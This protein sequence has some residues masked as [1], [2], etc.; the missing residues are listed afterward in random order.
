MMTARTGLVGVAL[1]GFEGSAIAGADIYGTGN[2]SDGNVTIAADGPVNTYAAVTAAAAAGTSAVTL[3]SAAGFAVGDLVLVHRSQ[4]LSP[5]A[6]SGDQSDITLAG[7]TG[8]W[9]FA[10]VVGI[11]GSTLTLDAPLLSAV[12]ATGAQVV[13]VPEYGNLTV[14]AARTVTAPA[15]DGATGGIVVFLATGTVTVDGVVDASGRGFRGGVFVNGSGNYSCSALDEVA[16][17]GAQKGEGLNAGE[18]GAAF[19]GKGN[20]ANGAGGGVC[21]NSG[22][23][24]GGHIGAGGVGGDTWPGSV[25]GFAEGGFGGARLLYSVETHAAFGGGGGAGHGNNNVG[26]SGGAGG[27]LVLVRAPT[28]DTSG[29]IRADGQTAGDTTGGGN[30]AAGGGGAGGAIILDAT[31][32]VCDV[33]A[34]VSARGGDGG[35]V[36]FATHGPGGGGGGGR[37]RFG[38]VTNTCTGDV[39]NGVAGTE[40]S[41]AAEY[42]AGPTSTTVNPG[43]VDDVPS[44]A[45]DTD[46]D[47]LVDAYE[48]NVSGTDPLDADTDNDGLDDGEEVNTGRHRPARRRHR[49]RRARPTAT[50]SRCAAPTRSTSTPTATASATA[51]RRA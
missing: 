35:N 46:G 34:D 36:N 48:E 50:R 30:D 22:G 26:T 49:R 11:A 51:S 6:A 18:Y 43:L 23:G 28:I 39:A 10:R 20:R 2:G 7:V 13:R 9:E 45:I 15:W 14:P 31:S 25:G 47:G 12:P 5:A 38:S 21:H 1:L 44:S 17:D 29:S 37:I 3:T 16:G 32:L 4:G 40:T 42:G 24:G 19:I 33:G 41:G 27:G 8:A